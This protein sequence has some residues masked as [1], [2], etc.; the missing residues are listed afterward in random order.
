MCLLTVFTHQVKPSTVSK[1]LNLLSPCCHTVKGHSWNELSSFCCHSDAVPP[2]IILKN[3]W[4][5][6]FNHWGD[7]S[8][9]CSK[10][11]VECG[12]KNL[13]SGNLTDFNNIEKHFLLTC[14]R[15]ATLEH[16]C[17]ERPVASCV[18]IKPPF[19]KCSLAQSIRSSEQRQN[20]TVHTVHVL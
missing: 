7:L 18:H 10:H 16:V 11:S 6:G 8:G 13:V 14:I 9:M 5:Q 12:K 19:S 17:C 3:R 4:I 15:T 1:T 2:L 20:P